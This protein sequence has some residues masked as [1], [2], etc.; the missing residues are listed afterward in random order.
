[1]QNLENCPHCGDLFV[2]SLRPVCNQCHTDMEK[3]FDEVYR[4]IR[5]RENRS[6]SMAE[7]VE[8]TDVTEEEIIR[9][10]KEGRLRLNQFPNLA[11]PC[12]SCGA[13]IREGR[14]CS[15]CKSSITGGLQAEAR[16]KERKKQQVQEERKRY[17]T[18]HSI[19]DRLK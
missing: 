7:V 19:N 15:S 8:A 1:M 6:A 17:Q 9:F 12:D 13:S 5:K 2:K 4:F 11:Y 10:I 16:E 18:Y 14:L 3:K